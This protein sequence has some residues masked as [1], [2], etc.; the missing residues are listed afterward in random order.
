MS[1]AVFHVFFGQIN[2]TALR[3]RYTPKGF[4]STSV[5]TV[6]PAQAPTRSA[7][8]AKGMALFSVGLSK[9]PPLKWHHRAL[10]AVGRKKRRLMPWAVRC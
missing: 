9:K 2:P 5:S 7:A 6:A 8:R 4:L 10:A 3:S 1:R